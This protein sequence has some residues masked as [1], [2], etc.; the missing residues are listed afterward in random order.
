VT[1]TRKDITIAQAAKI[2]IQKMGRPCSVREI[3][4]KII[5]LGLYEFNT[6]V[7]EHVLRTE[8]RRKTDG[9]ER[10][11]SSKEMMFKLSGDDFYDV[12]KDSTKRQ[13][14]IGM[15]RIQRANDKEVIIQLLT[16]DSSGVFKEIWRLLL[17]AA[18]LGFHNK[19]REPLIAVDSGKGIDQSSF[20]N[21]PAW[22]GVL[23]LLGLVET[24]QTDVLKSSE[25]SEE[26]RVTV[27]QEYANG[28]LAILKEEFET[29]N[30][31]I[32]ALLT[33]VQAQIDTTPPKQ[34]DLEITI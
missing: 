32:E 20:G 19:R 29:R 4:D 13:V 2:A 33:F 12:M 25:D 14:Q 34:P 26:E 7:P 15:K 22:P 6:P 17:F 28:G 9:V 10:C 1:S 24:S 3:Y 18:V 8:I 31:N 27:F 21:N 5:D 11:D 30:C 16:A 23:Y